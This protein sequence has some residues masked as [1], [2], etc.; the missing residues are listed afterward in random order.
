MNEEQVSIRLPKALLKRAEKLAAGPE[1]D[2]L[3]VTRAG[4][5]RLALLR[6][7]KALEA[8]NNRSAS[9]QRGRR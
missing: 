7:I 3:G 1:H 5:L 6:G 8:E 2:A 4:V 9:Q